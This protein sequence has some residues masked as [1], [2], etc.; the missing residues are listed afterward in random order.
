MNWC[1]SDIKVYV[2]LLHVKMLDD[3]FVNSDKFGGSK[4]LTSTSSF[5]ILL[6]VFKFFI[7]FP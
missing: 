3:S 5:E 4:L 1:H 6:A 2:Y 7:K